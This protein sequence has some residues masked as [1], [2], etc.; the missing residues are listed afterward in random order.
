LQNSHTAAVQKRKHEE[1][2][3]TDS[4]TKEVTI[5]V[6]LNQLIRFNCT[7][8]KCFLL[9]VN[10]FYA[11]QPCFTMRSIQSKHLESPVFYYS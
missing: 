2:F 10:I 11:T 9:C 3:E 1:I 5:E 6:T 7:V 8:L 4:Q